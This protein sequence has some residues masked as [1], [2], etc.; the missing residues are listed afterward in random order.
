MD[1]CGFEFGA[2]TGTSKSLVTRMNAR[3]SNIEFEKYQEK[4]Q[5]KEM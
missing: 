3:F 4:Y 5:Q 2:E 1:R